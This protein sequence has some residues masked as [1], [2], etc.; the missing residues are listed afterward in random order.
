MNSKRTV[1]GDETDLF[2]CC[3]SG[4]EPVLMGV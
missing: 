1:I 2:I 4:A 3:E